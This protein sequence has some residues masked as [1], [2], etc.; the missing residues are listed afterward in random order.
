MHADTV[1]VESIADVEVPSLAAGV[2]YKASESSLASGN[3][4]YCTRVGTEA[5]RTWVRN[6]RGSVW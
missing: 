4:D 6:S 2:N 1:V 3:V 5:K